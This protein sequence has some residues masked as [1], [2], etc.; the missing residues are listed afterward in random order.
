[1]GKNILPPEFNDWFASRN[2]T[3]RAHQLECLAA[4]RDGHSFLLIAPTGGGK[5]LAGFLPSLVALH[6]RSASANNKLHT[7]YISPLKALA[8]DV[9]RNV[10]TP[11]REMGLNIAIETRTGDTPPA[12]RLRQKFTPPDILMTTPES[13][14]V[15]IAS[16]DARAYFS[17]LK[18]VI[19]DVACA[20]PKQTRAFIIAGTGAAAQAGTRSAVLRTFR[21]SARCQTTD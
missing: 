18:R 13:L 3:V 2:W 9:A 20:D 7:L 19:L 11:V 21:D 10:E 8:V 4:D 12:R 15:L 17:G 5:T 1:M 16:P 14:S 6:E